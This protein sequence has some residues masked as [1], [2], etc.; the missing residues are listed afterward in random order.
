MVLQ[1]TFLFLALCFALSINQVY[2]QKPVLTIGTTDSPPL[3]LPDQSGILDRMLKEAFSRIGVQVE[4]VTLP[5]ERYLLEAEKGTID[6]DNNR[7]AGLQSKYPKLIQVPES[8]MIYEFAAFAARPGVAI[9]NWDDLATLDVAHI[10]GWKIFEDNVKGPRVTKVAN[11][12]QLFSLLKSGRTDVV[13]F[14]RF[15]GYHQIKELGIS[16]GYVV[17]PPLAKREMFLYLNAKHADLVPALAKAL[18]AM[19]ADGSHAQ[20][21]AVVSSKK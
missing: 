6:G 5:S 2:A 11:S 9:R 19:K 13:L 1:R 4:F 7:I 18:R 10:I 15:G 12:A 17:E 14:D 3:S 16:H 20:Y 21:F 8:S